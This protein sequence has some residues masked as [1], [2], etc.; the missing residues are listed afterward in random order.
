MRANRQN[1][2]RI[3][4]NLVRLLSTFVIGL[5]V[6]RL[7]LG[8]GEEVYAVI[9]VL[10]A[11]SGI[12]QLLRE[13]VRASMV[14][15]LGE[16]W[17]SDDPEQF[18]RT[19]NSALL[20]C[21]GVGLLTLFV[22]AAMSRTLSLLN[23]P[24]LLLSAAQIFFWLKALQVVVTVA[25]GPIVSIYVVTERLVEYNIWL[26]LERAFD[27]VAVL[28]TLFFFGDQSGPACLIAYGIFSTAG[29]V[30]FHIGPICLLIIP[31]PRFRPRLWRATWADCRHVSSSFGWNAV[32]VVAMQMHLRLD[33]L[34][35]NSWFGLTAGM[36]FALAG[37]F[38]SYVRV[39]AMGLVGGLDA[40]SARQQSRGNDAALRK[41]ASRQMLLQGCAVFPATVIMLFG[42][43]DLLRLWLGGR[44]ANPEASIPILSLICRVM[45]LGIAARSM[46]E[47]WM[48]IMSGSGRVRAYAPLV[49]A[50]AICNPLLIAFGIWCL[51][52]GSKYLAPAYSFCFIFVLVHLLV[53]PLVTSR[54]LGV[55]VFALFRPCFEPLA[56]AL[57]AV[58]TFWFS[59]S[60]VRSPWELVVTLAAY[61]FVY[62][63]LLVLL[64]AA[65]AGLRIRQVAGRL[66]DRWNAKNLRAGS[67]IK[68]HDSR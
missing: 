24:P 8:L 42:A 57:L 36:L 45:I 56:A 47:S 65:T 54:Q 59:P 55:S 15:K 31:H 53:L 67:L 23:I 25:S 29:V 60:L 66:S 17:H 18:A 68:S 9:A 32:Y 16:A 46:S 11:G 50:G 30:L 20:L 5:L 58:A 14:P 51:P 48:A 38:T 43:E 34:I 62:G 21:F 2:T 49:L 61:S 40:M 13:V 64:L 26:V 12:A 44:L 22:F 4:S 39:F 27:L 1:V 3:V 19:Y 35:M 7:L 28:A 37:Q 10:A 63:V 41:L 52:E 6:V 33:V